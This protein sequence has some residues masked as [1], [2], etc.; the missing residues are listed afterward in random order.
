[1][2]EA[3]FVIAVKARVSEAGANV[4]EILEA[5][6]EL[7]DGLGVQLTEAVIAWMQEVFR[8]RVCGKDRGAKK[9]LGG[10]VDKRDA[11]RKCRCR[12]FVKEGYRPEPRGLNTELG[13]VEFRVGY[14]SCVECGKKWAPVLD[15]LKLEPR[16]G[17][18]G[19][20][21]RMVVEA[22]NRTSFARGP[23]EV[24]GLTGVPSSKSSSH[25]WVAA[26]EVPAVKPP[27]E[28]PLWMADGTGFKK[29]GGERGELRVAIGVTT[30]GQV[31]PLGTW[32]GVEWKEIGRELKRRLRGRPK[33]RL[34]L[35]DGETGLAN[36]LAR[37]AEGMQRSRWHLLRDLRSRLWHDDL[38]KKDI[39]PYWDEL[40]QIVGMEIPAGEWEK[41]LP[42]EKAALR[43][44]VEEARQKFQEMI[45]A[46]ARRGYDHGAEYLRNAKDHIFT[47]IELWL[48]TGI[49]APS[50]TGLLEEIMREI[51]RRVK[52]LGW[53]WKDKGITQQSKLILVRRYNLDEWNEY[54]KRRMDL[55][56]RCTLQITHFVR[57]A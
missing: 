20:L 8:D 47:R 31:V 2:P 38:K 11:K 40:S 17:H 51:G 44:E 27:P 52:K 41:I 14:V 57:A 32:A 50:S 39:A 48:E 36:H 22:V 37:L 35:G 21:E 18:S 26:L 45:D 12:E 43:R 34:A 29:A 15:L 10:H 49:I 13:R 53:N 7:R 28:L 3:T 55:Q 30:S 1:M 4:N 6:R 16:Q 25:R 46:F 33:P 9:G 23:V 54:W 5:A 24:E 56:A 19:E 42:L